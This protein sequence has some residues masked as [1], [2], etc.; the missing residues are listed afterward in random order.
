VSRWVRRVRRYLVTGEASPVSR[1][2]YGSPCR[3]C[4]T[5]DATVHVILPVLLARAWPWAARRL[6]ATSP[7]WGRQ[8]RAPAALGPGTGRGANPLSTAYH[9]LTR[10]DPM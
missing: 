3:W 8:R 7:R 9:D 10:Y 4:R 2:R 6:H 1:F 5:V